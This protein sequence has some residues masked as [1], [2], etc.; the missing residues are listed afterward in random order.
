VVTNNVRNSNRGNND[1]MSIL[2]RRGREMGVPSFTNLREEVSTTK[3]GCA[4][5]SWD[6][7]PGCDPTKL[8]KAADIAV[9]RTLYRTPSDVELIVGSTLSIERV[10]SSYARGKLSGLPMDATQASLL[11][12]EITRIINKD[13]FGVQGCLSATNTFYA[14]FRSDDPGSQID[15]DRAS[16]EQCYPL[17]NV[18]FAEGM[19]QY[20]LQA[21]Q[22]QLLIQANSNVKCLQ[23]FIFIQGGF[24]QFNHPSKIRNLMTLPFAN[25][26]TVELSEDHIAG[27]PYYNCDISSDEMA[28]FLVGGRT[29]DEFYCS[30]D[31][32]G[33]GCTSPNIPFCV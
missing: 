7:T 2:I 19:I 18:A 6:G 8:W 22:G 15:T 24:S 12:G 10:S 11:I 9:L 23:N 30:E 25:G 16:L 4:W 3:S 21:G 32:D 33:P 28:A 20:A 17:N 1:I 29:Y 5:N 27:G 26:P 31:I 13:A 14:R